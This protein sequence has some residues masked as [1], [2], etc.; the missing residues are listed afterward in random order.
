MF[1]GFMISGVEMRGVLCLLFVASRLIGL[2]KMVQGGLL[3]LFESDG[4][5][6]MYK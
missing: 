3:L 2:G 6:T 5:S 4:S 1:T